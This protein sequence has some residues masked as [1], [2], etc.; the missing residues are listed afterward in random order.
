[1]GFVEI[2]VLLRYR[3][4]KRLT[5]RPKL[6]FDLAVEFCRLASRGQE[7]L[8]TEL[9]LYTSQSQSTQRDILT[10]CPG[11]SVRESWI[12][13]QQYLTF[14]DLAAITHQNFGHYPCF[15]RLND[16][17]EGQWHQSSFR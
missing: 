17:C 16:F 6:G 12:Q 11:V 4:Q 9:C 2:L 7:C 14:G 5:P 10:E 3:I 13:T 8:I 15:C 1:M